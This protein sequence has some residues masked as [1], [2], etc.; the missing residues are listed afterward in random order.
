M[1]V[2]LQSVLAACGFIG[3]GWAAWAFSSE[4]QVV[5]LR[6]VAERMIVRQTFTIESLNPLL[7][8]L[9]STQ[10]ERSCSNGADH[11]AVVRL[12]VAALT[13]S[14]QTPDAQQHLSKAY[15]AMV[16]AL[17]CSPH[18]GFLWYGLFWLEKSL[19]A[20]PSKYLRMLDLSYE[21]SPY[22]G[23]I[24]RFRNPDALELYPILNPRLQD[25]VRAEYRYLIRDRSEVAVGTLEE[26]SPVA[27][28]AIM[29][30]LEELPL[31]VRERFATEVDRANLLI[32]VPGID[33]RRRR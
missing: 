21:L 17:K 33:Y 1:Q 2:I 31:D 4:V 22:E 30:I 6:D 18:Q 19:G 13:Q 10:R 20:E 32:D 26:A 8:H 24:A 14:T 5:Q 7:E 15:E 9:D 27:R 29:N 25:R 23:W 12:Y 3:F 11:V 16:A 28:K